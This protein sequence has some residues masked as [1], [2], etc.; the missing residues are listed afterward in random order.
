MDN[1]GNQTN[2]GT[3]LFDGQNYAF[4][5]IRMRVFLQAQ[6]AEVWTTIL[7]RYDAHVNPPIDGQGNLAYE[8]NSRA[9]NAILSGLTETIFIKV[10][11]CDTAKEVW[12]KLKNIYEGD[13]KVKGAKL[14][15][16]RGQ[17]ENLK[18]ERGRKHCSLPSSN[19]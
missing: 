15:T 6:G 11:H 4:Q 16:Y 17:F 2:T 1:Q 10:M 8:G 12:D 3:H 7:T 14:Q 9:M 5:N 19:R 18:N 13:D